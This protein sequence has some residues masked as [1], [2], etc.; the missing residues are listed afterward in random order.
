MAA[1]KLTAEE[2]EEKRREREA[3]RRAEME[4][5]AVNDIL[6]EVGVPAAS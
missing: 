6:E 3:Q 4:A 2:M 5:Q 1:K